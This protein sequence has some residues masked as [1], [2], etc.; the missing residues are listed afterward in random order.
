MRLGWFPR[1]QKFYDMFEEVV[2]IVAKAAN[3][4][5][6]LVEHFDQRERRVVELRELEHTCDEAVGR[7]LVALG[8]AFVTPLDREDIHALATSLDDVLDNMEET[9]HRFSTFQIDRPTPEAVKMA[10]LIHQAVRHLEQAVRL[11]RG[12]LASP[13][14]TQALREISRL[15]NEVDAIFRRAEAD[16]FANPTDLP[17]LVKWKDLYEWLEATMD[18]CRH[19]AHVINNIV[20]KGT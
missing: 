10:L 8:R 1:D 12:Q 3:V 7:I 4:F 14:M 2:G 20:V 5:A 16:L 18:A 11:C 17:S 6:E 15:E 13:D 19:V 9:A